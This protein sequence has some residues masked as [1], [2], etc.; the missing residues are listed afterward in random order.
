MSFYADDFQILKDL[1]WTVVLCTNPARLPVS[2]DLYFCWWLGWSVFPAIVSKLIRKPCIIVSPIHLY[3][4]NFG[5]CTRPWYERKAIEWSLRH[6]D[7]VLAVSDIEFQSA[8]ELGGRNVVRVYHGVRA[9]AHLPARESRRPLVFSIGHLFAAAIRRKGFDNVIRAAPLVLDKHPDARFVVAGSI[10]SG[11][12]LDELAEKLG[13]SA[14]INFPGRI[15]N[16]ERTQYYSTARV[17][18]Q[19]SEYEG[20]GLAQLEAMSYGLPVVTSPSGALPEVVGPS[21]LYCDKDN[22]SDIARC[23][24]S[25]L[26][27]RSLWESLSR[28]GRERAVTHF[29][30]ERRRNEVGRIIYQVLK[31]RH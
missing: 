11:F 5:H 8:C 10:G 28:S 4:K 9:P 21:G 17:F 16:E 29:S 27:E 19:P 26:S 22:P 3:D 15:S 14:Y 23:I 20:F 25:L 7:A 1:G 30:Y 6:A 12:F 2:V 18:A 31:S 13:V 24:I